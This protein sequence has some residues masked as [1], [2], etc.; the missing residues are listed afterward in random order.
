MMTNKLHNNMGQEKMKK[1]ILVY[2]ILMML[3]IQNAYA[4]NYGIT[5][6]CVYETNGPFIDT[7][8]QSD[9]DEDGVPEIIA[10]ANS[11]VVYNFNYRNCDEQWSAAW[12]YMNVNDAVTDIKVIDI[13]KDGDKDLLIT[14]LDNMHFLD[15]IRSDRTVIWK[16]RDPLDSMNTVDAADVDND[17]QYEVVLGSKNQIVYMM[18]K[19]DAPIS[20]KL[21]VDWEASV[22]NIVYYVK[23]EDLDGDGNPEII[24]LTNDQGKK[25]TVYVFDKTGRKKW[26]YTIDKGVY[27]ANKYSIDVADVTR[28]GSKEILVGAYDKKLIVLDSGGNLLWTYSTD[29]LL[30]SVR[31]TD[32]EGDGEPEIIFSSFPSLYMIDRNRNLK[33]KAAIDTSVLS[34]ET[35]DMDRDG[36][37]EIIAGSVK[38]L[39]IIDGKGTE[40]GKWTN[41]VLDKQKEINARQI[42][43]GDFDGDNVNEIAAGFGWTEARLDQNYEFGELRVFEVDLEMKEPPLTTTTMPGVT[44]TTA[45]GDIAPTTTGQ[46]PTTTSGGMIPPTTTGGGG[47]NTMLM[48]LLGVG[49]IV[50]VVI[51]IVLA[52]V[53]FK[54]KSKGKGGET[55]E[56]DTEPKEK[57]I[58][59]EVNETLNEELE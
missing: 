20:Y 31:V 1:N 13:D 58:L 4:D 15:V 9:L 52:V 40:L 25:A 30:S 3:L 42:A 24:A 38:S 56:P 19:E 41:T 51:I 36:V 59:D 17:G 49:L 23:A 47:D 11:G 34:I 57:D 53:V 27:Q 10:G 33:W 7:V 50:V 22:D 26:E 29:R 32:L 54:L 37:K 5:S 55:S 8:L 44:T 2:G 21:K 28:D 48:L 12:Q 18:K 35:V 46:M 14:S 6:A 45:A 16:T 39:Q 43:V